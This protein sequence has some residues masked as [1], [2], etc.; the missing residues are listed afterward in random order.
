MDAKIKRREED[1]KKI[2]ELTKQ[3]PDILKIISTFGTPFNKL[4]IQ[5]DL[6]EHRMETHLEVLVHQ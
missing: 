5:I 1:L 2:N 4:E 6:P 3:Y